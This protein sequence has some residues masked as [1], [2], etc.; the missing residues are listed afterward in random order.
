VAAVRDSAEKHGISGHAAALRWTAFHS[1]LDGKYGDA[2]IFTV[3]R[4][5]QLYNTLDALEAGP[6]PDELAEAITT[7]YAKVEGLEPAYH[8]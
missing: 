2:V 8:L 1:I 5:E 7:M 3:S 6:L 4:M